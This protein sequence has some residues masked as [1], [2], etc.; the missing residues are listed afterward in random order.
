MFGLRLNHNVDSRS[1]EQVENEIRRHFAL[2][3][4][5][6]VLVSERQSWLP[7]FPDIETQ[8]LFWR[9]DPVSNQADRYKLRMFKPA[10]TITAHDFPVR[11][12]LPAF[13]DDGESD[14]C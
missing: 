7:G 8:V 12:L 4:D 9:R 3:A 10:A 6:I 13:V 5:D 2:A 1:L 11:W 14:C